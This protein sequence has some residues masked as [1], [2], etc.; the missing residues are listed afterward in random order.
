MEI[1][2]NFNFIGLSFI[3]LT[4][5]L[6]FFSFIGWFY[7]STIYSIFEQGKLM[8]RGCFI[9]PYCPI[10]SVVALLNLYLLSDVKSSLKIFLI[11]AAVVC[12]IEYITS[13]ALEKLFHARYWDY[14]NYP[15]NING[16]ISVPSGAFFGLAILFLFKFLFPFT[17]FLL[18][19]IPHKAKFIFAIAIWIIFV[20]DAIFTTVAMCE[21]NRKCKEIYDAV[22][23]YIEGKLDKI[24]SKKAILKRFVVVRKGRQL[25]LKMKGINQK[26]MELETRLLRDNPAFKSTK[27]GE[28]I[29]KLKKSINSSSK[30]AE[31]ESDLD[32]NSEEDFDDNQINEY[33]FKEKADNKDES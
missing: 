25:V 33:E 5:T 13:W 31:S 29:E 10:Y 24:N 18:E 6:F 20:C 4:C 30:Y 15:L 32:Y 27:Y 28:I 9:G 2:P 23:N 11:S 14:S 17:L 7:E 19:S 1:F 21:L 22:D 8:N 26:Y 16:R 12:A 3:D